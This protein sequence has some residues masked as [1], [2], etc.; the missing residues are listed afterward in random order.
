[1]GERTEAT[2]VIDG[3]GDDRHPL[4]VEFFGNLVCRGGSRG[5]STKFGANALPVCLLKGCRGRWRQAGGGTRYG[6]KGDIDGEDG[7]VLVLAVK[8]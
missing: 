2:E 7:A 5:S 6:A 3:E 1:M 8:L 4:L